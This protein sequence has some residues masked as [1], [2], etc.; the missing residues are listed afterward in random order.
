MKRFRSILCTAV[1]ILIL[2]SVTSC[3][4]KETDTGSETPTPTAEGTSAAAEPTAQS[5]PEHIDELRIGVSSLGNFLLADV[6]NA[7]AEYAVYDSIFAV[8]LKTGEARSDVLESWEWTDDTTL[9]VVMKDGVMFNNGAKA[10]TEDVLYSYTNLG[11]RG[12]PMLQTAK[13]DVENCKIIDE[14]TLDFKFTAPN[15]YFTGMACYLMNKAW[16]QEVGRMSDAWYDPV[17]SGRYEVTEYVAS[18][19]MVL[20]KRED[21]WNIAE[22]GEQYIDSYYFKVY[23]DATVMFMDLQLGNIDIAPVGSTDYNRF[24]SEKADNYSVT[25]VPTGVNYFFYFGYNDNE[26]WKDKRLREAIT[27]G[28]NWDDIGIVALGENFYLPTTALVPSTSSFYMNPGPREYDPERA[29]ELLAE[30][31]Y[32]PDNP[33]T[34]VSLQMT[35][36][37]YKDLAETFQASALEIGVNVSVEFADAGTAIAEWII[38]GG[39]DF[40][41]TWM[42]SGCPYQDVYNGC[43]YSSLKQGV[44]WYYLD[45]DQYQQYYLEL[46]A[47]DETVRTNASKTIQQ[48]NYDNFLSIPFS[49]CVSAIGFNTAKLTEQQIKDYFGPTYRLGWFAESAA[50][51]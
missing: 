44:S 46:P 17:T 29:K 42:W 31:G 6:D 39:N 40:G 3:K 13:L 34:L 15:Y 9:R 36:D 10:T 28:I 19:H 30:A 4:S 2:L 32:G 49:E 35:G 18:D 51:N 8:D 7:S 38:P 47:I 14:K 43:M 12:T 22:T 20:T 48:Y 26:I 21:Y 37:L 41:F 50:W 23:N 33:L 25:I 16:C 45:D 1:V 11:E 5:K 27:I 24:L